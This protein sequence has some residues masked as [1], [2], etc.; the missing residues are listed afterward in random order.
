MFRKFPSSYCRNKSKLTV[1]IDH[2]QNV[3]YGEAHV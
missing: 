3:G 1:K 2:T